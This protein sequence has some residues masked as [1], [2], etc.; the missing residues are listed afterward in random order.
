MA[1]E[2]DLPTGTLTFLFTDIEDS[3]RLWEQQSVEMA[4]ALERHDAVVRDA[5]DR[6]DGHVFS[7]GG[8]GY[9]AVFQ[10]AERAVAAAVDAQRRLVAEPWSEACPIRVRMGLHSG[11]TRSA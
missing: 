11:E 5:I 10:R 2:R 1:D 7:T 9:G 8:D 6:Y 3:T 4:A